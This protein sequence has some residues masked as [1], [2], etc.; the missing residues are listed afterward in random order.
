M[1]VLRDE[2]LRRR[3]VNA[4][5]ELVHRGERLPSRAG[6]LVAEE[7]R[8]KRLKY[9]ARRI[10]RRVGILMNQLHRAPE[11][12]E[13]RAPRLPDVLPLVKQ[14]AAGRP[15]QPGEEAAGCG[16]AAAAL[17]DEADRFAGI[18]RERDRVHSG[19]RAVGSLERAANAVELD[20]SGHASFSATGISA[21]EPITS[22]TCCQRMHAASCCGVST[23]RSGGSASRHASIAYGQRG[24]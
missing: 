16:L 1:R 9:G 21:F 23:A 18:E 3:K 7:G 2:V 4:L 6:L 8:R 13:V 14:S 12:R 10:E 15:K 17:P 20:E 24:A 22:A 5:Q 19:D 11:T